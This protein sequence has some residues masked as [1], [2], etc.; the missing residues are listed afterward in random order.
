M[1]SNKLKSKFDSLRKS[2]DIRGRGVCFEFA[3]YRIKASLQACE[4]AI[5]KVPHG[6]HDLIGSNLTYPS[7]PVDSVILRPTL[8][9]HVRDL[10]QNGQIRKRKR[11]QIPEKNAQALLCPG[12]AI[13]DF[14]AC[15]DLIGATLL[16][17]SP[18]PPLTK[19]MA[20]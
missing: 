11:R 6:V 10:K 13:S 19:A 20:S 7:P 16:Q 8:K 4:S 3:L 9:T 12:V 1:K 15:V 17:G 14:A 2:C 18:P 5:Q